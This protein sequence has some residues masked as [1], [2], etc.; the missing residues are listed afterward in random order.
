MEKKF[1]K[2]FI[3]DVA[4]YGEGKVFRKLSTE[5]PTQYA[6]LTITNTGRY[7]AAA[8]ETYGDQAYEVKENGTTTIRVQIGEV[9]VFHPWFNTSV[10]GHIEVNADEAQAAVFYTVYDSG[11]IIGYAALQPN[12]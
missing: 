10:T 5:E 7:A 9:L 6:T 11:T 12:D 4:L 1:T 3:G 2:L 8:I